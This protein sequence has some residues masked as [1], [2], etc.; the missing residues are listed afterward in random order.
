MNKERLESFRKEVRVLL[1]KEGYNQ[2]MLA[3]DFELSP[4]AICKWMYNPPCQYRI[5]KLTKW[6]TERGHKVN[7]R[8]FQ[9]ELN[10][11]ELS[12]EE[13]DL[14]WMLLDASIE[15]KNEIYKVLLENQDAK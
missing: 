14:I 1:A 4:V 8:K 13:V 10:L 9:K 2:L 3:K 11:Y 6:A 15:T 5:E 7:L 12:D